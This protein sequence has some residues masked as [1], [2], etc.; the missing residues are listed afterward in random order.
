M[1][2]TLCDLVVL[3]RADTVDIYHI[4]CDLKPSI[5]DTDFTDAASQYL[6]HI[7]Q[8]GKLQDFR[9]TRRKLG[10][11][12]PGLGEFHLQLEFEGLAQFDAAFE[13]VSTR[14]DPVESFHHGV[15]SKVNNVQFA[16]YPD[17]PDSHRKSGDE[18]F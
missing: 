1:F 6:V 12:A 17:F 7:K 10:F 2:R 8:S 14:E 3:Y 13:Q 9:I 11:G 16:L 4:W 18:K 5:K 15:N